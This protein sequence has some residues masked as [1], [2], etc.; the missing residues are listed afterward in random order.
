MPL[1]RNYFKKIPP[2]VWFLV[3]INLL[4]R[5]PFLNGVML[6]DEPGYYQG[7]M[8][9]YRNYLN[10]FIEFP[11]YKPPVTTVGPAILSLLFGPSRLWARL[12]VAIFS[13]LAL[14]F[15]YLLGK[16]LFGEKAGRLSAIFLFFFPVFFVQGFQFTDS[17]PLTGLF[18][19]TLYFY[20]RANKV[21]YLISASLLV[22]TKEPAIFVI[23]FLAIF[24]I[25]K[26]YSHLSSKRIFFVLS[27]S[28]LFIT[29]IT[30]S[31]IFLGWFVWPA[32]LDPATR[33]YSFMITPSSLITLKSD[34]ERFFP[35]F[36]NW[37]VSFIVFG[38]LV[39]ASYN[40][41]LKKV[42]WTSEVVFLFAV[43]IF[44]F[45][46]YHLFGFNPRYVLL[47]NACL[48][49]IFSYFIKILFARR[50]II[51]TIIVFMVI[52]NFIAYFAY[53]NF[54]NDWGNPDTDLSLFY[55]RRA[56]QEVMAYID[57][58]Y[59]PSAVL[60]NQWP[61]VGYWRRS[62]AGYVSEDREGLFCDSG[63]LDEACLSKLSATA[64]ERPTTT[65]LV[66]ISK[67][68]VPS[69]EEE[70]DKYEAFLAHFRLIKRWEPEYKF[71]PKKEI[72]ELYQF[73]SKPR[74]S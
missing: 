10:P 12:Y 7:V 43:A 19:A 15:I 41:S 42:F 28:L 32:S 8:N 73:I 21:G 56:H 61:W 18:L 58:N 67:S 5:L 35:N 23:L 45:S 64:R 50:P 72:I 46:F 60:V 13:S 62:F 47:A 74:Q 52:S 1:I 25:V 44:Y 11:G 37:P 2:L 63:E 34:I 17:L 26:N 71:W 40:Q 53:A 69:A 66:V 20:F 24:D 70:L 14:L 57:K 16:T 54:A 48:L 4:F 65:F 38:G 9:A 33:G 55:F 36:Y 30:L 3:I 39:F 22:L 51:L 29:W 59:G 49:L 27:P 68:V 6:N 31:K